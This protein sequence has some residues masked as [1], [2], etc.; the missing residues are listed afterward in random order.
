[1]TTCTSR[2]AWLNLLRRLHFYIGL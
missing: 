2:A 1:M